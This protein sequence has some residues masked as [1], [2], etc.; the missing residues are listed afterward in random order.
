MVGLIIIAALI[1]WLSF[2][3]WRAP[4]M[5][6]NEDGSLTTIRKTKTLSDLFKN[7]KQ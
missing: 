2:E 1:I 4:L 6:E 7:K 5:Q 3:V